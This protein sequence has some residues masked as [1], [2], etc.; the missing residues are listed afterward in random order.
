MTTRKMGNFEWKRSMKSTILVSSCN[1]KL[2]CGA[3]IKRAVIVTT[4]LILFLPVSLSSTTGTSLSS[5]RV[6]AANYSASS[7][8]FSLAN[9]YSSSSHLPKEVYVANFNYNFNQEQQSNLSVINGSNDKVV[10]TIAVG[11]E[12]YSGVYDPQNKEI[13]ITNYGLPSSLSII[14]S[15]TNKVIKTLGFG[16]AQPDSAAYDSH[17]RD[18][19]VANFGISTVSVI[20]TR[21]NNV[22]ATI[23]VGHPGGG[24][25]AAIVFDPQNNELYATG[26]NDESAVFVISDSNNSVIQ[27]ISD[28]FSP[29]CTD[30]PLAAAL[31][32]AKDELYVANFGDNAVEVFSCKTNTALTTIPVGDAPDGVAFD[33]SNKDM[34]IANYVGNTVSVIN[35]KDSVIATINVG[36][37]HSLPGYDS[38]NKEIYVPNYSSNT[39]SAI[40]GTKVVDT[41]AVGKD[42]IGIVVS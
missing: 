33:S 22:F 1:N 40:I 39:V 15:V 42:P 7:T 23:N 35:S 41:I 26:G 25:P 9:S 20:N 24:G 4:L 8:F 17:N 19:Y 10:G 5:A 11:Y 14:N 37:F 34:Y 21:T 31:D 32:P 28:C 27:T 29:S 38:Q 13:Y 18:V 12:P 6:S 36:I 30:S 2:R 16:N 3:F